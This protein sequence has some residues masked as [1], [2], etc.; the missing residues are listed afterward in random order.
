MAFNYTRY[1]SYVGSDVARSAKLGVQD[2]KASQVIPNALFLFTSFT[3]TNAGSTGV[4]GPTLTTLRSSYNTVSYPWINDDL[5]FNQGEFQGFQRFTIPK[6][7]DYRITALGAGG[8]Q[9]SHSSYQ[10]GTYRPLGSQVVATYTFTKG[11]QIQIIV[12]QK[13][14]DDNTYYATQ[15][16]SN[17][18]DN[19]APGGGGATWVFFN[20]SDTNPIVV[21]GGGAGGTRQ[22]YTSANASS[23]GL[24][25][26]D[27]QSPGSNG[28]TNGNGGGLNNTGGSYWAGAG[29]GWNSNG[30]GGRQSQINNYLPGSN[31]A[32]G[33]QSP[34]NGAWGGEKY[35][36]GTNS[37]GD[38]GFGGGGGGGSDNMGTGGGGGYSGGG[39]GNSGIANA[40]GG[41]GGAYSNSTNRV[42]SSSISLAP[43]WDHGSVL[44]EAL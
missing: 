33:G 40:G 29:A 10:S 28:G 19:A 6:D 32:Y 23:V 37:G 20:T 4:G 30:T 18:G 35:N 27:S 39:G 42:G 31:G 43:T 44:I 11:D 36:D 24:N 16:N 1:G 14:E 3:F 34:A 5:Y 15:N 22:T 12:G 38:G 9:K 13:G 26:N 25:G 41:G 17:E 21:A 8:G 7:G 2:I